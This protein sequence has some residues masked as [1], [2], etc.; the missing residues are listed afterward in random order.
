MRKKMRK[1]KTK[2]PRA[3][4]RRSKSP[5]FLDAAQEDVKML[6]AITDWEIFQRGVE[7]VLAYWRN[8]QQDAFADWFESVYLCDAWDNG[9]F[10]DGD[11]DRPGQCSYC[12]TSPKKR[13]RPTIWE[14]ALERDDDLLSTHLLKKPHHYKNKPLYYSEYGLGAAYESYIHIHEKPVWTVRFPKA[15]GGV[16]DFEVRQPEMERCLM[17][18]KSEI[19]QAGEVKHPHQK[20]WLLLIASRRYAWNVVVV[21]GS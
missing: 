15:L 6:S 5:L 19:S 8:H 7:V 2:R 4:K 9:P 17:E 18:F 12:N 14:I 13:R 11:G 20:K 1:K 21:V 16:Q 10:F 3:T